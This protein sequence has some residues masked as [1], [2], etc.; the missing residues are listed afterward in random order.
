MD[1][2]SDRV[3]RVHVSR[4]RLL[5][6]MQERLA[7][8]E[9]SKKEA[10]RHLATLAVQNASQGLAIA[11]Q[12]CARAEAGLYQELMSLDTLSSA[13]LDHHHLRM[14]RLSAEVTSRCQML[15]D[16]RI[17]QEKAEAA[18]CEMRDVWA[19]RSTA[20]H[21]WKQIEVDVRR[22]VDSHAEAAG[23]IEADDEIS[24]RSGRFCSPSC[25]ATGS[26]KPK[27]P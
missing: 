16:A 26:D 23:E 24:L 18:A 7:L 22:A 9:L 20:R 10:E 17:A 8:S 3:N 5:K 21:K 15:D 25:P 4:L 27:V 6:D 2:A 19:K 13:A 1:V 14:E 11:R 12:Q